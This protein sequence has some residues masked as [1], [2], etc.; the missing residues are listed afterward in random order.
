MFTFFLS[1][2]KKTTLVVFTAEES[3]EKF[4]GFEFLKSI[5]QGGYNNIQFCGKFRGLPPMNYN[6]L[7][8]LYTYCFFLPFF[9]FFAFLTGQQFGSGIIVKK[10]LPL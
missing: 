6:K 4:W 10:N 8:I 5:L 3:S 7:P 9:T 2:M 1:Y